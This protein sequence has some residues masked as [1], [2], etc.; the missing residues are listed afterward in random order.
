M[1]VG[2]YTHVIHPRWMTCRS[3]TNGIYM[4]IYN[5]K[6]VR[7][8]IN[9]YIY[10]QVYEHLVYD[11]RQHVHLASLPDMWDRVITVS[12]SGKTFSCTGIRVVIDITDSP[13]ADVWLF[14]FTHILS[15]YLTLFICMSTLHAHY[16]YI[17][18]Y[19]QD[20]KLVG[21]MVLRNSS[22]RSC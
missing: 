20:G 7:I 12:S 4:Y 17:Y 6:Y 1:G 19:T 16:I 21:Y 13:F 15:I 9:M 8:Y 14:I 3:A 11:G 2:R 18:T 22:N 5:Y 10:Y